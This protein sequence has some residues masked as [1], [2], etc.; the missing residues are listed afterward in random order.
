M[1]DALIPS[2]GAAQNLQAVPTAETASSAVAAQAKAAIEA[3]W[4][5]AMRQPRNLDQVRSELLRECARPSF[6]EVARYRKPVGQGVEGLSIR[7]VEAALQCM[8]NVDSQAATIYDDAEKRII[9]VT[10]TDYE[11]NVSHRKQLTISKVVE[12]R[13][14][15]QGQVP[16]DK[17]TNSRGE[18]IYIVAASD[19]DLANKEA[20]LL[21]KAVRT[22]GLRLIPGWLQDEAEQ[23]IVETQRSRAA[24][25]PDAEKR[26]VAD[27]F[28]QLGIDPKDLTQY[29]GHALA[30]VTPAELVELREVYATIRADET[31]WKTELERKL[32]ERKE[33]APAKRGRG[34][35]RKDAGSPPAEQKAAPEAADSDNSVVAMGPSA[36]DEEHR[37]SMPDWMKE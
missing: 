37:E 11:K 13:K 9:E 14:L 28:F 18:E 27:A 23:A 25:D 29:L 3:R 24:K 36:E 22:C 34:R 7:F 1:S 6:A 8:G 15:R 31:T 35:P 20:A 10:V 19:D 2:N 21:S 4:I 32:S 30:K 12:R 33:K 17:R 5:V 26:R 16:I